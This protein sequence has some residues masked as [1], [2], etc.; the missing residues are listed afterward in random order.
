MRS[1]TKIILDRLDDKGIIT[2]YI[3]ASNIIDSTLA[4]YHIDTTANFPVAST[5]LPEYIQTYLKTRQFYGLLKSTLRVYFYM[6]QELTY[7]MNKP[8]IDIKH[9]KMS[10]AHTWRSHFSYNVTTLL[11]LALSMALCTIVILFILSRQSVWGL[12]P[13]SK[14]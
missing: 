8:V 12:V 14:A 10:E 2:D 5:D 6:L 1:I 3:L 4:K 13:F 7:F 11:V 9:A